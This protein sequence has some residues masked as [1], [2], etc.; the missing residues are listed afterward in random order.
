METPH[1]PSDCSPVPGFAYMVRIDVKPKTDGIQYLAAQKILSPYF[2]Y[3]A[4]DMSFQIENRGQ[5]FIFVTLYMPD[6]L[7]KFALEDVQYIIG[8]EIAEKTGKRHLQCV[9]WFPKE[10]D[11]NTRTKMRNWLK[12]M[13]IT[14]QTYQ[15]VAIKKSRKDISLIQYCMKQDNYYTSL[16]SEEISKIPPWINYKKPIP[17]DQKENKIKL[18]E[19]T[20]V[21]TKKLVNDI[22]N[23]FGQSNHFRLKLLC[24]YSRIYFS[25]Y[26]SPMRRATGFQLL[27]RN[28][29]LS[30]DD[31]VQHLYGAFFSDNY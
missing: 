30:H 26:H 2:D 13:S 20:D 11:K 21:I 19:Q 6:F 7:E 15:N 23:Y 8:D 18:Y 31:Y 29:Q 1:D 3:S 28:K 24:N 16:T 17:D 27:F 22:D 12:K 25:I 9:L 4:V 5:A 14:A 10:L